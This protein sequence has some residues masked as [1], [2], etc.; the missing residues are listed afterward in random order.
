[1]FEIRHY[2]TE[3]GRNPVQSWLDRLRDQEAKHRISSRIRRLRQG[4]FGD[5]VMVGRSIRELRIHYG[6]GYRIYFAMMDKTV[7]LLL[8]GG[9]KQ[10]QR[11]D[12]ATAQKRLKDW[13]SRHRETKP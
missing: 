1:M 7:I 10:T 3:N 4:G 11:T 12:I 9:D 2:T 5:C 6:P 13:K 8:C